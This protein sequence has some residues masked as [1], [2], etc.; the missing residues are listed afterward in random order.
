MADKP[1]PEGQIRNPATKRCV[2]IDGAIGKKIIA[3][4]K[5]KEKEIKK[6]SSSKSSSKSPPKDKKEDL[7][8]EIIKH[9]AVIRNYEIGMGNIYKIRAYNS[10]LAQLYGFKGEIYTYKDFTDN[11][12]A[13][14]KINMK[15]KELIET[16]KIK[17]EENI[18]ND[19]NYKFIEE[20]RKI[21]GIGEVNI[22]KILKAG[23][24]SIDELKENQQLLNDKQKIGLKYYIDLNKK[25]PRDEYL[26]H[27][28]IL[29]NDLKGKN[30]TYD[31]VGSF[32]RDNSHMGDIDILIMKNDDFDLKS[33]VKKLMDNGY[34]KAILALGKVKFSGIVK[35]DEDSTARQVDILI[36]PKEEYYYSLL[37][38]TG[39]AEFNVG[40]RNYIKSKY[41]ISLSEHGFDK[42]SIKI[43]MMEKEKDIFNFFNIK[44]VEP[45]KRKVF[46]TPS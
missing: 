8:K 44:Y 29:E 14:D 28:I 19:E 26:K 34:I 39:S 5:A 12:K 27:K 20:L 41:G 38:F 21:Y 17:Y 1:C 7:K 35:L 45:K 46:F 18:V 25:I 32:R 36:S 43:P 22:N 6:K 31:F 23:I 33:Y 15:V 13:G 42:D 11:I 37:Y 40:M 4:M 9:I 10:V 24:K 30:L 3:E 2:K 16:N